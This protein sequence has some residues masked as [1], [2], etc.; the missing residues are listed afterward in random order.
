MQRKKEWIFSYIF[1]YLDGDCDNSI[2]F[3]AINIEA[4]SRD[5]S[6]ILMPI[7]QELEDLDEGMGAIDKNE[8]IQACL[9]LYQVSD[10]FEILNSS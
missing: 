3:N 5:V 10:K 6:R 8:F 1:D 9:R 4:V 2:S 7:V